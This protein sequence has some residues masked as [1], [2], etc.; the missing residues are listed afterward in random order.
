MN[1]TLTIAAVLALVAAA[2]AVTIRNGEV[3]L[4]RDG[5]DDDAVES[6]PALTGSD[7]GSGYEQINSD[8]LNSDIE[9]DSIAI[10][11][12][13]RD[14]NFLN[15]AND[16]VENGRMIARFPSQNSGTV[17]ATF[18][19]N[20][21]GISNGGS[22]R[23]SYSNGTE[24]VSGIHSGYLVT[25]FWLVDQAEIELP[26]GIDDDDVVVAYYNG[27]HY[28]VLK[29]VGGTEA[30]GAAI[31]GEGKWHKAAL[32][33][34]TIPAQAEGVNST[35]ESG[36]EESGVEEMTAKYREGERLVSEERYAYLRPTVVHCESHELKL[37]NTEFMFPFVSV[38]QCPQEKMLPAI[39]NTLVASAITDDEAFR[40][41]LTDSTLIDRLNLGALPT[42]QLNWLQPHEGNI[43]EFLFR[44]RALQTE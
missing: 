3:T 11:L 8:D 6:V 38:V 21:V 2:Q 25:G 37:A 35:I 18:D 17:T 20:V 27:E 41:Q 26:D 7:I 4:F 10:T 44:E 31:D 23:V 14:G 13:P 15:I 16:G 34:F 29:A 12:E 30:D 5:F 42:I 22:L 9:D 36:L 28:V 39:S 32:A 40:H 19:A 33:A 43:V 24:N 1:L